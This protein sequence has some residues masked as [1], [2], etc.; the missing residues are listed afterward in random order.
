MK[1]KNILIVLC[2][3]IIFSMMVVTGWASL[4]ENVLIGG[5][6]VLAEPWGVAT[7]FD[8][9]FAFLTFYFWV[10]YKESSHFSKLIWLILILLLG[11]MAISAYLLWQLYRLP[12]RAPVAHILVRTPAAA[13]I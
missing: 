11:N 10:F 9:Y 4:Y 7:M 1:P 3:L 5:Q 6:K 2:S 12:P 13:K 8:T